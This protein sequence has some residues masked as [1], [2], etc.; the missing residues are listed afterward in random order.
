M[1]L[2]KLVLASLIWILVAG[3]ISFM[4]QD[5]E[6][7]SD[8]PAMFVTQLTEYFSNQKNRE[9]QEILKEF[10]TDWQEGKFTLEVQRDV[11]RIPHA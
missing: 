3:F 11:I 7:F 8:D 9:T 6:E 5:P 10:I 4:Q 1:R 2:A